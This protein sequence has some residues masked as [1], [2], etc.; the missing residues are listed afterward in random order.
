MRLVTLG[1]APYLQYVKLAN[2][3]WEYLIMD[4]GPIASSKHETRQL[5]EEIN[6]QRLQQVPHRVRF[7][8]C[9]HNLVLLQIQREKE[10]E[11]KST[12]AT[13]LMAVVIVMAVV[14]GR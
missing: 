13:M 3:V 12:I 4:S 7:L 11:R 1:M 10:K 5:Y 2:L 14:R 9:P 8:L 6:G